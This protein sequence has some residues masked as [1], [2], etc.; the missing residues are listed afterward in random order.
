M[1]GCGT[2]AGSFG[3]FLKRTSQPAMYYGI[4][5]AHCVFPGL[6]GMP[7]CSPSAVEVT[8]RI[9]QLIRHTT[10]CPL[11]HRLHITPAKEREVRGLLERSHFH[12]SNCKG[13]VK[14]L[15][16]NDNMQRKTGVLCGQTLGV[17]VSSHFGSHSHILHRY[18]QHL[19]DS[20]LPHFGVSVS[21]LTRL[22]WSIFTCDLARYAP[23]TSTWN[24]YFYLEYY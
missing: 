7:I 22:D 23:S 19:R 1:V 21:S 24:L 15:D 14:F 17:I 9:R 8:G 18:D 20:R 10:F 4:T 13:R 16:P 5:A 12:A 11:K 2:A 6:V 3:G